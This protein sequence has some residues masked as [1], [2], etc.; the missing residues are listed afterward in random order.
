MQDSVPLSKRPPTRCNTK[1]TKNATTA[2]VCTREHCSN[3]LRDLVFV[4]WDQIESTYVIDKRDAL[5]VQMFSVERVLQQ[6]DNVV[7]DGILCRETLGPGQ[8]LPP[9]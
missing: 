2:G 5:H 1:L 4:V 9:V 8:N 7:A 3:G 6:L